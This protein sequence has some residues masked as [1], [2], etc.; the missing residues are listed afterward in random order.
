VVILERPK[1]APH[2]AAMRAALAAALALE[3]ARVSVKGKTH[4]GLGSLGRG[5]AVAAHAVALL[6]AS[7]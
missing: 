5:E 4:E 1:L 3:P 7:R 6:A 2:V